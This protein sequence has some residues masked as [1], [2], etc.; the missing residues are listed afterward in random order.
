LDIIKIVD[1]LVKKE[2]IEWD[3]IINEL[4]K[5]N[6]IDPL[7]ID[8]EVLVDYYIKII[9]E[10]KKKE[11]FDF[12]LS[13]NVL[14][15]LVY[16]LKLKVEHLTSSLFY[17]VTE[18][19]I[20]DDLL[21]ESEKEVKKER[22]EKKLK[23]ELKLRVLYERRRKVTLEDLK[24]AIKEIL[25]KEKKKRTKKIKKED[26]EDLK[27]L[28][29]D[30][31]KEAELILSLLEKLEKKEI[32]FF[33]FLKNLGLIEKEEIIK[34]FMPLLYLELQEKLELKQELPLEDFWI[35]KN[36]IENS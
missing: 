28:E 27:T 11:H 6:V 21:E 23:K 24:E 2:E 18:E 14:I 12:I 34:K 20:Y 25:E 15:L 31:E 32:S 10:L 1:E 22:R 7:N 36:D 19:V 35:I 16:F 30:L 8:L 13:S 5:N 3:S 33:E 17:N 4:V 26:L 9:R 29:Y